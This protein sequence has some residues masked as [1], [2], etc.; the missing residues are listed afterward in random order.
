[1]TTILIL[2]GGDGTGK[3]SVANE[4]LERWGAG[5]A[6]LHYGKPEADMDP[7]AEYLERVQSWL[8]YP[9]GP[10]VL[11]RSFIGSRVWSRLGFHKPT[12]NAQQWADV[13]RWYAHKGARVHVLVKPAAEIAK[14]LNAR[15]ESD[16][17]RVEAV[18]GQAEF[19]DMV[20]NHDILYIPLSVSTDGVAINE[21]IE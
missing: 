17:Q 19:M 8:D 13:C 7:V 21:G 14:V 11:D 1:M 20:V 2:E 4:L 9:G 15:G 10:V 12:L 5:T 18:V 16:S 6:V 3:S